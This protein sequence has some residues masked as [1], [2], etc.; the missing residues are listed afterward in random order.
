MAVDILK[1]GADVS[2]MPIEYAA[3][4]TKQYVASRCEELGVTVPSDYE[5]IEE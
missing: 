2:E 1:N 5:A 4:V 3:N